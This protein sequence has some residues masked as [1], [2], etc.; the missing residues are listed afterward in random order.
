MT[1]TVSTTTLKDN[2]PRAEMNIRSTVTPKDQPIE[3]A[4]DQPTYEEILEARE[5]LKG[6]AHRTKIFTSATL[7]NELTQV[8][9]ELLGDKADATKQVEVFFKCENLQKTGSFKFRGAFN[10]VSK[11]S[12]EQKAKGVL[13]Y[14]AGNHG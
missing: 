6:H 3:P 14:S 1:S 11:L 13:A 5:N 8:A 7:N 10:A 9:N 2:L 4:L 12:D